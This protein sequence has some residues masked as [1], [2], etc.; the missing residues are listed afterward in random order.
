MSGLFALSP[1]F[2]VAV[3]RSVGPSPVRAFRWDGMGL[4]PM[5]LPY[6]LDFRADTSTTN[7]PPEA[8]R[9]S[10]LTDVWFFRR[11]NFWIT[12]FDGATHVTIA[13]GDRDTMVYNIRYSFYEGFQPERLWAY[14]SSNVFFLN[15]DADAVYQWRHRDRSWE[16]HDLSYPSM[17]FDN[18]AFDIWGTSQNS[19]FIH[20]NGGLKRYDGSQWHTVWDRSMPSLC[21]SATFGVPISG[22]A[23]ADE[24]SMWIT[25]LYIG[26]MRKDGT[27]KVTYRHS[28]KTA[29]GGSF[30]CRIVRGSA[31]NNVFFAGLGGNLV[32]FNGRTFRVFEE[33]RDLG[34]PFYRLAVFDN[35]V[36]IIGNQNFNGGV[37]VHG[38]RR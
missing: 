32:H 11:D 14:D 23:A 36:F 9:S 38:H 7:F 15:D 26:R 34:T 6:R 31:K 20:T 16:R 10:S 8:Y 21:D 1:D 37:F 12:D 33:F 27:G 25:G 4:L 3:G 13:G 2:V 5:T 17:P 24:D 29:S 18:R 19:V 28:G 30:D 22:W 35:D